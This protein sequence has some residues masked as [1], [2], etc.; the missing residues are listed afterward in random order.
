MV[1]WCICLL[2]QEYLIVQLEYNPDPGVPCWR[3][4]L[5]DARW[6]GLLPE[7]AMCWRWQPAMCAADVLLSWWKPAMWTVDGSCRGWWSPGHC[8]RTGTWAAPAEHAPDHSDAERA[9]TE[10]APHQPNAQRRRWL[11]V[12]DHGWHGDVF[13][14][15]I[16]ASA[17]MA[18]AGS[19]QNCVRVVCAYDGGRMASVISRWR[20]YLLRLHAARR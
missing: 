6:R 14:S 11:H 8:R 20:E 16:L 18:S 4:L 13:R 10:R 1:W 17:E 5:A 3:G 2:L 9:P 15:G 12:R 7:L 19:A